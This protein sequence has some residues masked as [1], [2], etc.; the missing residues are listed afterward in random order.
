MHPDGKLDFYFTWRDTKS[1][2]Y[3]YYLIITETWTDSEGVIWYKGTYGTRD[4]DYVLGF[5]NASRNTWGWCRDPDTYPSEW[6]EGL[7]HF[8][9]YHQK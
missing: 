6:N 4:T 9:Y 8:I 2:I 3:G 5:I 1:S 7:D